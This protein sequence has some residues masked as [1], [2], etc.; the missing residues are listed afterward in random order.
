M[1]H[2]RPRVDAHGK[3]RLPFVPLPDSLS[4]RRPRADGDSS[5]RQRN[6]KSDS[7]AV[8]SGRKQRLL[9]IEDQPPL[10][11]PLAGYLTEQGFD[12]E[13][14]P[15]GDAGLRMAAAA[16]YAIILLDLKL[17]DIDGIEFLQR[18]RSAGISNAGHR[19]HGARDSAI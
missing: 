9:W 2:D 18:L 13:F 16:V 1:Q 5:R 19:H 12:V 15:S 4:P 14:A 11:A 6:R 7:S 17:P 8:D 10:M 3:R